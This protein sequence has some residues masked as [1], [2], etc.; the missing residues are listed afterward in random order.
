MNPRKL[1]H[2][3]VI[4][5]AVLGLGAGCKTAEPRTSPQNQVDE[6]L[7]KELEREKKALTLFLVKLVEER[8]IVSFYV[9]KV[10]EKLPPA[11]SEAFQAELLYEQAR[12]AVNS[13]LVQFQLD[14]QEAT[15]PTADTDFKNN[16]EETKQKLAAFKTYAHRQTVP[17]EL[18]QEKFFDP[19]SATA[20]FVFGLG[21][22]FYESYSA[23]K[24]A[25]AD[26]KSKRAKDLTDRI[27]TVKWTA[28][29]KEVK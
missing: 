26:Q 29:F 28:S 1:F 9:R 7:K 8:D 17:G 10:R 3:V 6:E 27:E 15:D 2:L 21:R 20:S 24:K 18:A 13:M 5:G 22:A 25:N 11:S 12:G 23:V 19:G 16:C 4:A 14:L